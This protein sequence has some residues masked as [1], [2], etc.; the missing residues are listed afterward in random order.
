MLIVDDDTALAEM[1]SIVL[2]GEGFE[3]AVCS[4]GDSAFERFREVRPDRV[5]LDVLEKVP[6]K[7]GD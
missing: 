5:L 3:P 6:E 7:A 1:L 2:R 4:D